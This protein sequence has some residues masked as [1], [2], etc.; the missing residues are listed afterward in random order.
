RV[1]AD[2]QHRRLQVLVCTSRIEDGPALPSARTVVVEQAESVDAWRLHRIIGFFSRSRRP[3]EAWLVA[4]EHASPEATARL[5]RLQ[6][7]PSGVALTETLAEL[8]GVNK[9]VTDHGIPLPELTWLDLDRDLDWVLL[10]RKEA[11][12]ILDADSGLRRGS[13][14]DLA[15][16]LLGRW[17]R[18]WPQGGDERWGP[19]EIKPASAPEGRRRRRRRRRRR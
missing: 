15:L 9:V 14:A 13:H 10:A 12:A 18:F 6:K 2:F 4:G 3:A 16:E 11:R 17:S 5:E 1:H 8:S 7:A 19:P